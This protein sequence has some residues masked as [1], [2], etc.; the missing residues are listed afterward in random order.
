MAN[1]SPSQAD[2][3]AQRYG[4]RSPRHRAAV[5][6]AVVAAAGVALALLAWIAW[7]HSTGK[8]DGE[9]VSFEVTS[10]HEV[11]VV[12][13]VRRP[14]GEPTECLLEARA[15]DRGLV[16]SQQVSVPEAGAEVLRLTTS[17]TTEREA[18]AV[19]V[20]QCGPA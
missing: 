16:A 9:V 7:S 15:A 10:P 18:A 12:I 4:A 13:E 8:I 1:Q 5:I 19:S 6:A 17:I 2:L 3:L 11:S 14:P 20:A